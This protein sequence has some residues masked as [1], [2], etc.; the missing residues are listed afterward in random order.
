MKASP[1]PKP[2]ELLNAV[3]SLYVD[4]IRPSARLLRKR[5]TE[6][7]AAQSPWD[8]HVQ[9]LLEICS[10]ISELEVVFD[11]QDEWWVR[12]VGRAC[13]FVDIPS[14]EDTY[15][16][17]LWC[18]F[19]DYFE[20]QKDLS[21]PGGRYECARALSVRNLPFLAGYSLGQVCHIVQLAIST[22]KILGY[23]LGAIVSYECSQSMEKEQCAASNVACSGRGG[24]SALM[25]AL[26]WEDARFYL[27]ELLRSSPTTGIQL[28][29]V[30][31]QMK[32]KFNVQLSETAL[33]YSKVSDLLQD[34]HFQDICVVK[35][36]G[37]GYIVTQ[38]P[39]QIINLFSLLSTRNTT[40][41]EA[42]KQ[43]PCVVVDSTP[44]HAPS[45][46]IEPLPFDEAEIQNEPMVLVPTPSPGPGL[47]TWALSPATW[48]KNGYAGVVHNT[49]IDLK[50]PKTPSLR[51]ERRSRTEPSNMGLKEG[52]TNEVNGQSD[53]S[54]SEGS[55]PSNFTVSAS[56]SREESPNMCDLKEERV[57]F[58]P[59]EPLCFDEC[60]PAAAPNPS[61]TLTPMKTPSRTPGILRKP[62]EVR[63]D[64]QRKTIRFS[65]IDE[66][67]AK[68][69]ITSVFQSMW[70]PNTR[71][72]HG[73]RER[74]TFLD[75]AM[76]PE[77]PQG[78]TRA[79]SC[80][81]IGTD[82]V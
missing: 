68:E 78:P 29:N 54:T 3:E 63:G 49:F 14:L 62:G 65:L 18:S 31:R 53:D 44:R 76:P 11:S 47:P 1:L 77:T 79:K 21:L 51:S 15:S 22:K 27:L 28:P 72:E 37:Q 12:L 73:I 8:V 64:K 25:P 46:D 59:N 10:G 40:P 66:P 43:E 75:F 61:I 2:A 52:W 80:G 19:R 74:N 9:K 13:D 16:Q 60:T 20:E 82:A 26:S 24:R 34:P 55:H 42:Q 23:N 45:F 70:T 69:N 57:Q 58:C 17:E 7:H 6:V 50:L 32:A 81:G 33:G 56:S 35:E 4:Q 41:G 5:L 71:L 67:P 38:A 36:H 48:A 39:A 30:K